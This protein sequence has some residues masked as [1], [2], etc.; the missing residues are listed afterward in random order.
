[1]QAVHQVCAFGPHH[2]QAVRVGVPQAHFAGC[3]GV[4]AARSRAARWAWREQAQLHGRAGFAAI[5]GHQQSCLITARLSGTFHQGLPGLAGE[6]RLDGLS[7]RGLHGH[8]HRLAR[9]HAQAFVRAQRATVQPKAVARPIGSGRWRRALNDQ[10]ALQAAA[11]GQ[12]GLHEQR[13]GAQ[14]QCDAV[15]REHAGGKH[16]DR[17]ATHAHRGSGQGAAQQV[18]NGARGLQRVFAR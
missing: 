16:R 5:R 10:G 2:P 13:V 15:A 11:V 17:H 4:D 1:V 12:R 18:H 9:A 7:G 6:T 14:G 3:L 8:L